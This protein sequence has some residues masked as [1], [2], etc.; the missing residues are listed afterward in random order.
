MMDQFSTLGRLDMLRRL[1]RSR[2]DGAGSLEALETSPFVQ[3]VAGSS[4]KGAARSVPVDVMVTP[5]ELNDL[6]GTGFLVKRV[7]AGREGIVSLRVRDDY[8]GVHDFGEEAHLVPLRGAR[9]AEVYSAALAAV[10]G[11]PVRAVYSVPYTSEDLTLAMA[12]SDVS[13]APLCLWEMD[14]Q[15]I[16]VPNIPRPLMREFLEKCRIRFATHAE[17][18]DAYEEAFGLAFGI[19]PAVVPTRLVRK[20]PLPA[21][22]PRAH[23]ALL[24]SVWSRRWLDQLAEV[25]E[26][27]GERLEWYGNH[28]APGLRLAPDDL[29]AMPIEPHG[30]VKEPALAEA[31]TRHPFVVVPTSELQG[32]VSEAEALAALSLPGR[33]LFAVAAAHSPVLVVGSER[34]PAA[35]FVRRHAIGDVVPYDASA[36]SAAAARLRRPEKQAELRENARMLAPSLSDSGIGDWLEQ[37]I[38]AGA[39]RD[40]RF[41]RLF[42]RAAPTRETS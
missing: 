31:L 4:V 32:E 3:R 8:G 14:D 26:R 7:F 39:P 30:V 25:L 11:R 19:L 28:Q 21:W 41:E 23:G 17:L 2:L 15:C 36:F 35:A 27:G 20:D 6:H 10:R 24:G 13:G 40:D 16:A 9:R 37:S 42:P 1:L 38:A 33:I 5:G 12:V 34:T 29:A 22:E 18:R